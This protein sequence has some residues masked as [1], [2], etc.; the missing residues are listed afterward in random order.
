MARC[1]NRSF[2]AIRLMLFLTNTFNELLKDN[3]W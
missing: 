1:K 2:L 3:T